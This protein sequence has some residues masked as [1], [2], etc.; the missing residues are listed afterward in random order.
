MT[1]GGQGRVGCG[2]RFRSALTPSDRFRTS[3]YRISALSHIQAVKLVKASNNV[4][5]EALA[6]NEAKIIHLVEKLSKNEKS[7]ETN[8]IPSASQ[9]PSQR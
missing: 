5:M 1:S 7:E 3:D 9:E 4:P 2:E 6:I 8:M